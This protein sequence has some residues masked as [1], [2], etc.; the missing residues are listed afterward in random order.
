M[1]KIL[2]LVLGILMI[3]SLCACETEEIEV[4]EYPSYQFAAAEQLTKAYDRFTFMYPKDWSVEIEVDEASVTD[5]ATIFSAFAPSGNTGYMAS[6][7]VLVAKA[8]QI[9]TTDIKKEYV[10]SLM[11]DMRAETGYEFEISEFGYYNLGGEVMTIYTA[12]TK[13]D[14]ADAEVTQAMTVLDESLYVFNINCYG[15]ENR[16]DVYAILSSVLFKDS[17][18]TPAE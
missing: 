8:Q 4:G 12:K 18:Q 15:E 14:G 6:F 16:T 7:T 3:C 10:E 13:I 17:T 5:S 11:D 2:S 9:R 1:K